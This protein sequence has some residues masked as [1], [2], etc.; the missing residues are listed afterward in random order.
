MEQTIASP[1][2][3]IMDERYANKWVAFS[4]D[5]KKVVAADDTLIALDKKVGDSEVVFTHVLPDVFFAP[6]IS[7]Q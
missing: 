5:Y 1:I 2:L 7:T 6:A 4:P 3:P